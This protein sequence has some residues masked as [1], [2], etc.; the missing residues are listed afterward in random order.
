MMGTV[1]ASLPELEARR[2]Q[3]LDALAATGD[4]RRGS[5]SVNY[6]RCGKANC[7]CANPAHPGHGPRQLWTHTVP[8]GKTK[9]RQLAAGEVGKVTA[10]VANYRRFKNVIDKL[11]EVNEDICEARPAWPLAGSQDDP[12]DTGREKGGSPHG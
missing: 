5:V 7:A 6:R 1:D 9:G 8:G 11:I 10:E 4:S 2:A 12:A 3:L